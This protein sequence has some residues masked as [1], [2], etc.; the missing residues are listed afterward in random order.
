M[1]NTMPNYPITKALSHMLET[2][3]NAKEV[4]EE[5]VDDT[6][7]QGIKERL[8]MIMAFAKNTGQ[9]GANIIKITEEIIKCEVEGVSSYRDA[10]MED[11]TGN[12]VHNICQ[13]KEGCACAF[14]C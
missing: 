2:I 9:V 13:R 3:M 14:I 1:T 10:E 12:L 7:Q 11:E 6:S 8:L 5:E 4:K